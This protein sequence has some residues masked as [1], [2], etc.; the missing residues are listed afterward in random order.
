VVRVTADIYTLVSGLTFPGGS[1]NTLLDLAR[2]GE[3]ELAVS[4]PILEET[5]DVLRQKFDWPDSDVNEARRQLALFTK[6]VAPSE[7]INAVKEDPDDNAILACAIEAGSRYVVS[8]DRHLLQMGTF[9]G[10]PILKAAVF[11]EVI[12]QDRLLPRRGGK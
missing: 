4:D 6:H 8:G 11:L 9:R 1:P 12:A 2:T 10:V 5:G 7:S 3:I